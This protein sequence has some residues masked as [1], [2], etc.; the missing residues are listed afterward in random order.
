MTD[1]N[2][3]L[4][5]WRAYIYR[6][7]SHHYAGLEQA[8]AL[9]QSPIRPWL[10][11]FAVALLAT[12]ASEISAKKLYKYQDS[13]GH[14]VFTDRRPASDRPAEVTQVDMG[15]KQRLQLGQE[16]GPNQTGFYLYNDYAGPVECEMALTEQQNLRAVPSLPRRFTIGAG[17]SPI[18]FRVERT[19]PRQPWTYRISYRCV[20]GVPGARVAP[21]IPYLPPLAPG[22]TFRIGQGFGGAFSHTNPENRYAVDITMPIGTPVHAARDGVVMA[23]DNDFFRNG[24]TPEARQEANKIRILHPDG[25]MAVYAHLDLERA[26]VYPNLRIKAGD[27]IGYSGNTGYSTGPHLHF[28]VQ[29]NTGMALVS[30]PFKFVT[31]SGLL[32]A[33][34]VGEAVTRP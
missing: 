15:Q 25:S 30:V 24:L 18:L 16:A 10:R 12:S 22:A 17:K 9:K 21:D 28:A 33:P 14:W 27:L 19:D 6:D 1:C 7:I 29:I 2:L 3:E 8:R 4:I 11:A 34:V 26:T 13:L 32:R 31:I 20:V 23:V 5:C